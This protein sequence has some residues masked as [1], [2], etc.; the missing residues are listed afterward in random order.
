M[1][2]ARP[3]PCQCSAEASLE[4]PTAH[5]GLSPRRGSGHLTLRLWAFRRDRQREGTREMTHRLRLPANAARGR[6]QEGRSASGSA[7]P[8][9]Q[10][11]SMTTRRPTISPLSC[12]SRSPSGTTTASTR[13]PRC[14]A[15]YRWRA[16]PAGHDPVAGD[17][18]YWAP[19]GQ[20]VLYYDDAAPYWD[21][22]VRI[23]E[24]H[25]DLSAVR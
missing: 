12:R 8:G 22:I 24:V 14:L 7:A 18:G 10:R 15:R 20:L 1:T 16:C 19:D 11:G 23:G 17:I 9:S 6:P 25:G 13:L 5:E 21:G 3:A 4:D 2:T